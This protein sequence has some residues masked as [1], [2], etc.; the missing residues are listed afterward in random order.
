MKSDEAMELLRELYE[1][2]KWR[3][4]PIELLERVRALLAQPKAA[5]QETLSHI[6]RGPE[7]VNPASAAPVG[8]YQCHRCGKLFDY[9]VPD[10]HLNYCL[11]RS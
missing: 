10:S 8:N 3:D 6:R 9:P 2:C 7:A 11:R 1:H 4:I 5:P